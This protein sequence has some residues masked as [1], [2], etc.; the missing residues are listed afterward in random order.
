MHRSN[1]AD[2]LTSLYSNRILFRYPQEVS[3]NCSTSLHLLIAHPAAQLVWKMIRELFPEYVS[4]TVEG[5]LFVL[6]NQD[7]RVS[8]V[9]VLKFEVYS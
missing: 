8:F 3:G 4:A 2:F 7:D 5:N 6:K 9:V 1:Q